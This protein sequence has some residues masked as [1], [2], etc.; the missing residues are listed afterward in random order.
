MT[1][2]TTAPFVV[3]V[4][5]T[6]AVGCGGEAREAQKLANRGYAPTTQTQEE[7]WTAEQRLGWVE[8]KLM[9]SHCLLKE[10]QDTGPC[11][12][13]K[14]SSLYILNARCA[15]GQTGYYGCFAEVTALTNGQKA[16]RAFLAR[17]D[18]SPDG[19]VIL[20]NP[21]APATV[22]VCVTGERLCGEYFTPG[23]TGVQ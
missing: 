21:V 16:T 13:N 15:Q 5:A 23:D 10:N 12:D 20:S 7:V 3:V 1:R 8:G 19:E 22:E 9:I 4:A 6:L 2:M 18:G 17:Y 14:P 11:V